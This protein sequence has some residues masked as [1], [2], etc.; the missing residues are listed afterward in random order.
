MSDRDTLLSFISKGKES[1]RILVDHR[2]RQSLTVRELARLGADLEFKSLSV[3][4]YVV[5]EYVAIE[6]KTVEDF[7]NSIIDRRLFEQARALRAAYSRPIIIL[8]GRGSPT[9]E[10]REESLT[11]AL[12]SLVM[13]FNIPVIRVDDAAESARV[14]ITI[15]KREERGD[16]RSISL[17]DRRKPRT[18]DEEK[19]YIVASL[20]MVEVATAKKLLS[21]FGSVEKVFTASERELMQVDGIGPKKAKRIREVVTGIYGTTSSCGATCQGDPA[22]KKET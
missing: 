16:L 13:D 10:V 7:A 19:E 5:S 14:I 6:R 17:K 21:Y 9:R 18:P 2:E 11:G 8:E 4:D 12:I 22:M 3:G 1:L 15:A 20:P